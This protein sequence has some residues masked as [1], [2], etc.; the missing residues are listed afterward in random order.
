MNPVAF[1]QQIQQVAVAEIETP[2]GCLQLAAT[3][4][5]LLRVGF[6]SLQPK[7][8]GNSNLLEW[9]E[10]HNSGDHRWLKQPILQL[11]EYF[12]GCRQQF[13]L[14]LDWQLSHGFYRQVLQTVLAVEYGS[15]IS[16]SEVART[17][18]SPKAAR[19]VGTAMSTNPIA[20]VV[21]CHRVIRSDGSV[22]EY[23]GRP[24]KKVWLLEHEFAHR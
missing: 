19:A 15:T 17:V 22:G 7:S 23:A 5:G 16:Y 21:P 13:S 3:S 6:V 24:D 4:K 8:P 20:L 10:A 18:G 12:A 1:L 14:E 2:I 9:P 11:E